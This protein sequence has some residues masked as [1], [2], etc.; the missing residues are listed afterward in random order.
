MVDCRCFVVVVGWYYV[1]KSNISRSLAQKKQRTTQNS[2]TEKVCLA[3]AV[4]NFLAQPLTDIQ[5]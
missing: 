5:R 1:L 4:S 2:T 3:L